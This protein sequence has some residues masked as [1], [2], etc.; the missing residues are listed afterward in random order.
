MSLFFKKEDAEAAVTYFRQRLEDF[1]KERGKL[2]I[3][4]TILDPDPGRTEATLYEES[5]FYD[6]WKDEKSYPTLAGRKALLSAREQMH[7]GDVPRSRLRKGDAIH[8]GG[9]YYKGFAIGISGLSSQEDQDWAM[10]IAEQCET[11]ADRNFKTWKDANP[12][13]ICAR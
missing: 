8:Q 5:I 12:E 11:I 10:Q 9:V 4:I 7:S 3:H 2:G 1:I 13:A 6:S